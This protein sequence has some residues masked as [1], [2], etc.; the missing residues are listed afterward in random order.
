VLAV[1]VGAPDS[2]DAERLGVDDVI[3]VTTP[4]DFGAVGAWYDDFRATTD[5]EVLR[6]LHGR[7]AVPASDPRPRPLGPAARTS[8]S[9]PAGAVTLDGWLDVPQH[10][11]GL[12][13]FVHGSGSSRM[14]PRN[15][16]VAAVLN[17]HGFATLLFDL[18]TAAESADRSNVFDV[19]L[20]A[21]RLR[22]ALDWAATRS[23]VRDAPVGLFGASTGAA[24]ALTVAAAADAHVDA[25]V[26]RGGRP[27]LAEDALGAV[28]CPVLL[29]VGGADRPTFVVNEFAA[30][31]LH[32]PHMIEIVPGAG[33]LFE[34][35]GALEHVA[36]VAAMWFDRWLARSGTSPG[37]ARG[38]SA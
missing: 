38:R 36:G 22:W 11:R 14:S 9:I 17:Q 4:R 28:R 29:V 6:A 26:S 18:L 24:A 19:G 15:Q 13:V 12:V 31:R 7:R 35:P 21:R 16:A 30:A 5:A 23:E 8:V 33:H 1:P 20:L 10:V 34:E 2:L 25:V 32:V 3:A 27:D 37:F